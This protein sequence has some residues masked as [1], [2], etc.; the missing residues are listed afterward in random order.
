MNL[1][2]KPLKTMH[3][4]LQTIFLLS[5]FTFFILYF[6]SDSLSAQDCQEWETP[7][8][9]PCQTQ[10]QCPQHLFY[11]GPEAYYLRRAKE[12]G[13]K[14]HG[15]LYG[16]RGGYDRIKRYR[17][18]WGIEGYY[19]TGRIRGRS[20]NHHKL[21]SDLQDS[22]IEG[23][24]GYTFQG[25]TG[26]CASFTP[27]GGAG[28]FYQIN[29]FRKPSPLNLHFRDTFSYA[30]VGFLSNFTVKPCL[31][32]GVNFKVKYMLNG[33]SKIQKDPDFEDHTIQMTNKEQYSLDLPMSYAFYLRQCYFDL[34]F[35]PFFQYRHY[36]GRENFPFDFIDT[37]FW[38]YGARL[39]FYYSF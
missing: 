3:K 1:P 26:L 32:V 27:F 29:K 33:R 22:E 38:V 18:Y 5:F 11:L 13:T 37:K 23:R 30:V 4:K 16:V 7:F 10:C 39:L 19:A 34:S 24:L 6:C 20:A 15:V 2:I 8:E 35:V 25:K 31:K 9:N 17:L 14:Q 21:V 36:G 12:G 28:Y